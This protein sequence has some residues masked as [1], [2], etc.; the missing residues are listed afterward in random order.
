MPLFSAEERGGEGI[1]GHQIEVIIGK[2][3]DMRQI[4]EGWCC[5]ALE[6]P[7]DFVMVYLTDQLFDRITGLRGVPDREISGELTYLTEAIHQFLQEI[8]RQGRLA[9]IETDYAGGYGSQAGVLYENGRMADAPRSG[10]GT[11]N[12]LLHQ[13]GVSCSRGQDEF[14]SLELYKYRHMPAE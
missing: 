10:E 3:E 11:V 9:Y 6:L 13:L 8:S 5:Q 12:Q 14:D 1:M 7:Q 2:R 4:T